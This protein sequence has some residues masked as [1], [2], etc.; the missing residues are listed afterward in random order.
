MHI[1]DVTC[2]KKKKERKKRKSAEQYEFN[3]RKICQLS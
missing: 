2:V 1:Q 3:E